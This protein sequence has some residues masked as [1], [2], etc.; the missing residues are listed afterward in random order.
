MSSIRLGCDVRESYTP[1]WEL[2]IEEVSRRQLRV[3]PRPQW[4]E[5]RKVF[6]E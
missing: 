2:V 1:S 4:S 5:K 3:R 6:I